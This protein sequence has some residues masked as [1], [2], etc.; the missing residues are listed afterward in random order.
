MGRAQRPGKEYEMNYIAA[1]ETHA[2]L[3][4]LDQ[5]KRISLSAALRAAIFLSL[6]GLCLPWAKSQV[7]VGASCPTAECTS[8]HAFRWEGGSMQDL[9]TLGGPNSYA[10]EINTAGQVVGQAEIS[11]GTLHAFQWSN[12]T[13][14]DLGTFGGAQSTAYAINVSG[15]IVGSAETASGSWDAFLWSN[16]VMLDLGTLPGYINSY[17][18]GI[19]AEGHVVGEAVA[20]DNTYHAF[21]WKHGVMTDLGTLPGYVNSEAFGINAKGEI[22][23]DAAAADNTTDALLWEQGVVQDLG[24]VVGPEGIAY[25]INHKGQIAGYSFDANSIAQGFLLSDGVAL[26]LGTLPGIP[27]NVVDTAAFWIDNEGEVVGFADFANGDTH[28]LL[29]SAGVAQDLGTLGG[30]VYSAAYGVVKKTDHVLTPPLNEPVQIQPNQ[31]AT[32]VSNLTAT[33][34]H[35]LFSG[36]V[37]LTNIGTSTINGPLQ[38][39]FAAM[40]AEIKLVNA[41]GDLFGIPYVTVPDASGLAIGQSIV[42]PVQFRNPTSTPIAFTLEIYSGNLE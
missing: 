41:T 24:P 33:E 7:V 21:L 8:T 16:G 38:V 11:P 26:D 39:I 9:G 20:A 35:N 42:I 18:M 15:Q 30:G 29:W 27:A 25:A 13:M 10:Y 14:Q 31:I 2:C 3:G 34:D 28:A 17:A 5:A 36:T 12:G 19:N 37:T 6:F 4:D 22:V 40:P 23:G 1:S 32:N